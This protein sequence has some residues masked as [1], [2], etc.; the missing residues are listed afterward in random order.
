MKAGRVAVAMSGGVDS[1]VAAALLLEEGHD[2]VGVTMQVSFEAAGKGVGPDQAAK[3]VAAKLG[4][5]HHLFDLREAFQRHVIE[6]FCGEYA[7]GRTPNPCI[8]CNRFVKF[9]ALREHAEGLGVGH[10]ATG[11]YARTAFDAEVGRWRLLRGVDR[12]KDQSYSLY[13]LSQEQLSRAVFPLGEM[14]KGEVRRK[15]EQ[16]G[17]PSAERSE[18]QEICFVSG[19]SYREYLAHRR[20]DLIRPGPI[21]DREGHQLGRHRGT[22]FYTIGQR[23]GLGVSRQAAL[24]VIDIDVAH[25]RLVVGQAEEAEARGLVMGD[26][27]YVSLPDLPPEG[28]RLAVKIRSSG[29]PAACFARPQGEGVR[30]EFAEPQWAVSPGQAA[31]CYDG[32]AVAFGGIIE[33]GF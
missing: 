8:R 21:V 1:S 25:N 4:I 13:A 6:A 29:S 18:S 32:E 5:P 19:R 31:V 9:G 17:L 15:A 28:R 33:G 3:A 12:A 10:L 24:Y 11:H 27:N 23:E 2:L 14:T 30:V 16:L 20:P 7:V 22:A 26:V